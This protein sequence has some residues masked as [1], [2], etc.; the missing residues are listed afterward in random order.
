MGMTLIASGQAAA[1]EEGEE[2]V[3]LRSCPAKW[4]PMQLHF[5]LHQSSDGIC[6][7]V[8]SSG[9]CQQQQ[10]QQQHLQEGGGRGG[11]ADG[12]PREI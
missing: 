1:G 4:F 12:K 2:E 10:H 6:I 11:W 8:A 9:L 7:N 3:G 5:V